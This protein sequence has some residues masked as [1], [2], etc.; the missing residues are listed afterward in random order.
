MICQLLLFIYSSSA[1]YW[2]NASWHQRGGRNVFAD[3][4]LL[5]WYG[6][7]IKRQVIYDG[8]FPETPGDILRNYDFCKS[9]SLWVSA[10]W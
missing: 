6:G 2:S 3:K 7:E 4:E 1:Y 8:D 9:Q 5:T 10:F